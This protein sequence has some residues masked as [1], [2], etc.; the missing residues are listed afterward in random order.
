M[1]HIVQRTHI[2]DTS[3][4]VYTTFSSNNKVMFLLVLLISPWN[5][6]W[7]V[8]PPMLG[9]SGQVSMWSETSGLNQT[10]RLGLVVYAGLWLLAA[11]EQVFIVVNSIHTSHC[12]SVILTLY[13]LFWCLK[14]KSASKTNNMCVREQTWIK[15]ATW[16]YEQNISWLLEKL[17]KSMLV[18]KILIERMRLNDFYQSVKQHCKNMAQ[19]VE[20]LLMLRRIYLVWGSHNHPKPH[21]DLWYS[22]LMAVDYLMH[23]CDQIPMCTTAFVITNWRS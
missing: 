1:F 16:K 12:I 10:T 18:F 19:K 13:F 5:K 21:D 17:L 9:S 6:P 15:S 14:G 3:S 2:L 23:E 11:L 8:Q 7:T 4:A 22:L 20:A